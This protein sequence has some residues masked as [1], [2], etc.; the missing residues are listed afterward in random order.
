MLTHGS[1]SET[2]GGKVTLS[3]K[4]GGNP[5]GVAGCLP[6]TTPLLPVA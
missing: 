2:P 3:A 5:S 4:S 6:F 1:L